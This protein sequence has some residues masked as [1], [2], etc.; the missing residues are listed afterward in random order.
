MSSQEHCGV[1]PAKCP[2]VNS[3]RHVLSRED[4]AFEDI[5]DEDPLTCGD[6]D[7]CPLCKLVKAEDD[8]QFEVVDERN[9][10]VPDRSRHRD[11]RMDKPLDD[12]ENTTYNG[13]L[14]LLLTFR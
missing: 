4:E 2:I 7:E 11:T 1:G 8:G 6:V 12:P 5:V 9:S 10:K 14:Y 3:L 13:D